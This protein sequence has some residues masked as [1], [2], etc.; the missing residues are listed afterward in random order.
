MAD[1]AT[2]YDNHGIQK[3]EEDMAFV[4]TNTNAVSD[5][6]ADVGTFYDLFNDFLNQEFALTLGD[7]AETH[8][9]EFQTL[10]NEQIISTNHETHHPRYHE[11]Y[12]EFQEACEESL[13]RFS[14][15]YEIDEKDFAVFVEKI[16]SDG[17]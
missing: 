13:Q 3:E 15:Q 11:I 5:V 17:A 7:F 10:V 4:M 2:P 9:R 14:E 16:A 12:L 6:V 8:C 1:T